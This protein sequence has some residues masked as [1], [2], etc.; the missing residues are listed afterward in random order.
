MQLVTEQSNQD[1]QWIACEIHDGF[2]QTATAAL[3]QLEVLR[4]LLPGEDRE[5]ART[6]S[7]E[8]AVTL[9]RASI[10]E[11]RRLIAEIHSPNLESGELIPT[12]ECFAA[13]LE[14]QFGIPIDICHD[15]LNASLEP[16]LEHAAY[17]ILQECLRNA[18]RHS[19]SPRIRSE[20]VFTPLSLVLTVQ[21]WGVGFSE[22]DISSGSFGL[23]GVRRRVQ[24][25]SGKVCI[26]SRLREGTRVSV[27]LPCRG[28]VSDCGH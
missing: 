1:R 28:H 11:A 20:I 27:I 26:K 18:C 22:T 13:E 17:R 15:R 5:N 23:K 19:R 2:I 9:L 8:N 24:L 10:G 4:G 25:L 3:M 12:V 14:S 6:R 21:D 7:A 16:A